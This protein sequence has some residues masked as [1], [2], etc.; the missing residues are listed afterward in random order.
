V[1]S[2]TVEYALRAVVHLEAPQAGR[3]ARWRRDRVPRAVFPRA[4]K[5][6][7]GGLVRSQGKGSMTL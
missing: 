7:R 5:P 3:P 6:A 2:Q 1:F 4:A